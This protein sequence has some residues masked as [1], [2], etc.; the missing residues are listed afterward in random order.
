[1]KKFLL[2]T[3]AVLASTSAYAADYAVVHPFYTPAQGKFLS[4]TSLDYT[5]GF[6][7]DKDGLRFKE[8]HSEKNLSESIEY[9]V[10]NDIQVGLTIGRE[11]GKAKERSAEGLVNGR[12]GREYI[13]SWILDAGYNVI[14]DGKAFLNVG[15]A[16]SQSVGKEKPFDPAQQ[17][18]NDEHGKF[19]TLNVEGGYNLDDF[20]VFGNISYQRQIDGE[21]EFNNGWWIEHE[22]KTRIYTLEAGVFKAFND[23]IS[24]RTSLS[25]DIT[26]GEERV[27]WLNAGTD[28]SIAKDMAVGLSASYALEY[29]QRGHDDI[30]GIRISNK[31][32]EMHRIYKL[33]VDFKIAF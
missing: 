16:Y 19:I 13:N 27:Y 7:G 25:A 1:M 21:K 6:R 31:D 29:D 24:A 33:G 14:N 3:A 28:Y 18:K 11:W 15:L 22:D 32:E 8:I 23:Q 12:T 30:L 20:T 4:T 17:I 9:G 2:A 10:T 5:H 26:D